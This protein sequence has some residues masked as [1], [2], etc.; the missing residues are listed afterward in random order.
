MLRAVIVVSLILSAAMVVS[1]QVVIPDSLAGTWIS[2]EKNPEAR[3]TLVI[4]VS[5]NVLHF[6]EDFRSYKKPYSNEAT[7][8]L[9]KKGEKNLLNIPGVDAPSEVY[10]VTSVKKDKLLRKSEYSLVLRDTTH[11]VTTNIRVTEEYSLSKDGKTL[12]FKSITNRDE[13]RDP[14]RPAPLPPGGM[15]PEGSQLM[16]FPFERTYYRQ[17]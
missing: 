11:N 4:S 8:F 5:G 3:R 10:S 2:A 1:A 17:Q 15:I 9:D 16:V 12:R 14:I 6:K 13:R 7:L